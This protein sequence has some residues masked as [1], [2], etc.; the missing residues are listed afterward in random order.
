[1]ARFAHYFSVDNRLLTDAIVALISAQ[2]N[3]HPGL[4]D[5]HAHLAYIAYQV[6]SKNVSLMTKSIALEVGCDEHVQIAAT[7]SIVLV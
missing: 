4:Q 7:A 6:H 3:S 1:M 2:M 5:I